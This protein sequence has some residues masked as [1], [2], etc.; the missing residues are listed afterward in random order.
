MN[1]QLINLKKDEILWL[2]EDKCFEVYKVVSGKLMIC[3]K[4]NDKA[5]VDL[6]KY[7]S[8]G[9]FLGEAYIF[10]GEPKDTNV[11]CLEDC[12]LLMVNNEKLITEFTKNGF[13]NVLQRAIDNISRMEALYH[14]HFPTNGQS[15]QEKPLTLSEGRRFYELL[16]QEAS[17]LM[18]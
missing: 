18:V 11:I 14:A 12:Q 3:I 17:K 5:R 8:A 4:E 15:K 10:N 9:D 6:I 7:V 16:S 2:E 13:L 1:E